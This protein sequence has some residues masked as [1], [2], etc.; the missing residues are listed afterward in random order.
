MGQFVLQL[1]QEKIQQMKTY[2]EQKLVSV[3]QG[4]VFRAKTSGATITAY[5]SGK[6]LFQG[7]S[8]E[9]EV[10]KWTAAETGELSY[11]TVAKKKECCFRRTIY[12]QI[13]IL[14]QTKQV[15]VI[16]SDQLRSPLPM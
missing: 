9:T 14:E 3:P 5:R 13:A 10:E 16:I 6:V 4:A 7:K 8:P 15:Q 1:S 11:K 2:Y 12:F